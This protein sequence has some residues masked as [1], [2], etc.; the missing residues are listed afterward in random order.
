MSDERRIPD[1]LDGFMHMDRNSEA[2]NIFRYWT[3]IS[4]IAAALQRK[5]FVKL[6]ML[7]WYPNFY[8][9][10]VGPSGV[11]KG[12]AMDPGRKMLGEIGIK[13]AA[14][15]T[16]LQKL[17]NKM[18]TITYTE[19][20]EDGKMYFH[21][22]LTVFSKE[23]TVFLGY[24][25]KELMSNLCDWYDCEDEWT[26]ET[27]KRGEDKIVGVWV[28]I[29]GATTPKLIHTSMPLDA[30][31]GGLTSRMIMVF[32]SEK[33][34]FSPAPFLS[35]DD[36]QLAE[37]LK[38]DLE[39]I[40]MMRGQFRFTEDFLNNWIEWRVKSEKNPPRLKDDRF[41]GYIQRR[42][43]HIMKM[44]MVMSASRSSIMVMTADDLARAITSLEE[45][46]QSM[47]KVFSG[48]GKSSIAELMPQMLAFIAQRKV[49]TKGDLQEAFY[50]DADTWTVERVLTA[51][52]NMGYVKTV[53]T[54][55]GLVIKYIRGEL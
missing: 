45:V 9:L 14:Q 29:I 38:I 8:I 44:C 1:W 36:L 40:S 16:S 13:L 31:G 20:T 23:F 12:T 42:P 25:N 21:S 18:R 4:C 35:K 11:R 7:T 55:E 24:Q 41:S 51:F 48:V 26:Y 53:V 3:G 43:M 50:Y 54:N 32:E 49:C 17:I 33:G 46:E 5:C 2:P 37:E 27:L 6:G 10:L 39:K 52:D 47:S 22:S 30:I 28:N 15:A 34:K 19:I